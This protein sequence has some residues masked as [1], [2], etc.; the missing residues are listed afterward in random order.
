MRVYNDIEST[1]CL[2]YSNE[3]ASVNVS[4][5]ASDFTIASILQQFHHREWEQHVFNSRELS[6]VKTNYSAEDGIHW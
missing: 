2:I 3:P 4:I 5:D 6:P 1:V